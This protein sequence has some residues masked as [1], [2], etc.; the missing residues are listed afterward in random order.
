MKNTVKKVT[1]LPLSIV[2]KIHKLVGSPLTTP[3]RAGGRLINKT[4]TT[5]RKLVSKT[6]R[7]MSNTTR[8]IRNTG[9]SIKRA[10][11]PYFTVIKGV[12]NAAMFHVPSTVHTAVKKRVPRL[13]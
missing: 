1:Q 2:R 8:K 3:M 10:T 9:R 6:K 12:G 11:Q 7:K 13:L 5:G 4:K